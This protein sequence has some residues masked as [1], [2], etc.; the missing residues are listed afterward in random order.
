MVLMFVFP[1]GGRCEPIVI[2]GVMIQTL[3]KWHYKSIGFTWG[4]D[5]PRVISGVIWG[6]YQKY[7]VTLGDHLALP[8]LPQDAGSWQM[9]G[10]FVGES[11]NPKNIN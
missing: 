8:T 9:Q 6:P 3:Y 7:L 10:L 5:S 4:Y 1:Q 2:N 11:P